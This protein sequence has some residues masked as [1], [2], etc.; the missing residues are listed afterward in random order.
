MDLTPVKPNQTYDSIFGGLNI[1]G[2]NS[3]R[4]GNFLSG[5]PTLNAAQRFTQSE[6]LTGTYDKSEFTPDLIFRPGPEVKP[7]SLLR[8]GSQGSGAALSHVRSMFAGLRE[9]AA[10]DAND[11]DDATVM[12]NI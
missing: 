6:R 11:H 2:E 7:G 1:F 8:L 9:E 5:E 12:S 4:T 3:N 10:S